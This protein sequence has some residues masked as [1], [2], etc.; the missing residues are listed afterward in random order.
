MAAPINHI[1]AVF[2]RRRVAPRLKVTKLPMHLQDHPPADWPGAEL[3][4]RSSKL[5]SRMVNRLN[6]IRDEDEDI[7]SLDNEFQEATRHLREFIKTQM[8][9]GEIQKA[10]QE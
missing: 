2:L 6:L 9:P 1:E 7:A 4:S 8:S 5:F 3:N 10:Q